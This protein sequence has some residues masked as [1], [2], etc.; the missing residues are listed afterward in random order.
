MKSRLSSKQRR[1]ALRVGVIVRYPVSQC[2]GLA[3]YLA[4]YMRVFVK[5]RLRLGLRQGNGNYLLKNFISQ[6]RRLALEGA[7]NAHNNWLKRGIR[8][9]QSLFWLHSSNPYNL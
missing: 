2:C 7:E 1:S 3:F 5:P 4:A 9:W 8:Y 6:L